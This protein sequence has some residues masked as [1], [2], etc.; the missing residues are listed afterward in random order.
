[1]PLNVDLEHEPFVSLWRTVMWIAFDDFDFA[2]GASISARTIGVESPDSDRIRS[3]QSSE[4]YAHLVN[5]TVRTASQTVGRYLE[6]AW[7]ATS[8]GTPMEGS[9]R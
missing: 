6:A 3:L 9:D 5:E 4:R 8:E 1:M 2:V 7:Q